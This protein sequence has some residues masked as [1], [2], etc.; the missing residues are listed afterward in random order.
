M[1][2][3]EYQAKQLFRATGIPVPEGFVVGSPEQAAEVVRQLGGNE[4]LVKA[5]IH[6]GG[7]GKVGGVRRA[8]GVQQLKEIITEMLG[9]CLVTPQ[10]EPHGQPVN[11]V[12]VECS[13]AVSKEFYLGAVVD[14]ACGR[15]V[16]MAT[17]AGGMQVEEAVAQ[18]PESIHRVEVDTIT[19]LQPFQCRILGFKLGLGGSQLAQLT[20]ILMAM[21]R[22]FCTQDLSLI[23]INP[24]VLTS[25][26][27]L[28]ALDAKINVDEN[29]LPRHRDLAGLRDVTQE[30]PREREAREHEL[31]Y[32]AVDGNIGCVVNGAGLAMATMDLIKFYG[33]QPANFLDVGGS[34]TAEHVAEAFKLVLTD[35]KVSAILVNI[36]GGIARCDL[37]AEGMIQAIK[38]V[39]VRLPLV[40]RLVGTRAAEGLVL[41]QD[42]GLNIVANEDLDVAA[43]KVVALAEGSADGGTD[44]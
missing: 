38:E 18:R 44:R 39:G 23:E 37:I 9:M 22:L 21:Y 19:G 32:V 3:H 7:R 10:N 5:Q 31:N 42:S 11:K 28:L 17:D 40:V 14:S 20:E 15:V 35:E 6:A 34:T 29:A 33:G 41:L 24:L 25:A 4:W 2:L 27:T 16:F 30:D 13:C 36:F 12:L 8:S 26:G 1:N 43:Q